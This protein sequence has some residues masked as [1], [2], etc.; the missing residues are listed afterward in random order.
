MQSHYLLENLIFHLTD[1]R[2]TLIRSDGLIEVLTADKFTISSDGRELQIRNLGA[3]DTEAQLTV[4]VQKRSVKSKKKIK[5]RVRS[6]IVD[7]STTRASGIGST[8][9]N[10]GLTYGNYPFG[11]RVQDKVISL[12]S[13]DIIEIHGIY[14]SSDRL[15]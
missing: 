1:E 13:P 3:D 4:T 5:N 8:T 9:L 7:K 2:Y 12:N 6:L 11:T 14:E 15:E 10:D